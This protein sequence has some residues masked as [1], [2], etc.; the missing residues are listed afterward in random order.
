MPDQCEKSLKLLLKQKNPCENEKNNTLGLCSRIFFN[1]PWFQA[2][3]CITIYVIHYIIKYIFDVLIPSTHFN[4]YRRKRFKVDASIFDSALNHTVSSLG[5]VG[6]KRRKKRVH[7]WTF[8]EDKFRVLD[9][10]IFHRFCIQGYLE[11]FIGQTIIMFG[12]R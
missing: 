9:L 7:S 11:G 2:D 6:K 10:L 4:R 5:R 1:L 12:L 8:S 3:E